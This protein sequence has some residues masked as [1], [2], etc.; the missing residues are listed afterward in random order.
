MTGGYGMS[1]YQDVY[2]RCVA[3]AGFDDISYPSIT[4]PFLPISPPYF[5]FLSLFLPLPIPPHRSVL[6]TPI[7]CPGLVILPLLLKRSASNIS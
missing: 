2:N 6:V 1:P 7:K 5:P 3:Q 4:V